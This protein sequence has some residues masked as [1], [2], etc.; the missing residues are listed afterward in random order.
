[1]THGSLFSG[2]GGFDLAAQWMGWENLFHCEWNPFGQRV[3][4]HYWPDAECFTDIT[5]SDFTSYA[6]RIDVLS[7][8]FPCQPYSSAGKR[9]GKEDNRHLWP[10][11]LRAI[12]EVRPRWV[13]GENVSGLL[14]WNEGMVLAEIK[15]DLESLGYKVFT[16]LHIGAVSV[17][18]PH[19]RMRVWIVAHAS[20]QS[21]KPCTGQKREECCSKRRELR[22]EFTAVSEKQLTPDSSLLQRDSQRPE[23]LN[24]GPGRDALSNAERTG[25]EGDAAYA[26]SSRLQASGTKRNGREDSKG[27]ESAEYVKEGSKNNNWLNFPTQSPVCSRNDGLSARLSGI[28]FPKHRNESIK[29]YGNAIVP[30]VAYQ[31]F[32][33]IREYED[34]DSSR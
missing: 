23:E 5:K 11:M 29:A 24:S 15:A 7:G 26:T 33:A 25:S 30:Q 10:Q 31:I 19:R 21:F 18:A 16:P 3:L 12:G 28:S 22:G 4:H 20:S 9:L 2:I 8:G 27:S 13:V 6:N 17:N 34:T 14:N 32:K 1:M